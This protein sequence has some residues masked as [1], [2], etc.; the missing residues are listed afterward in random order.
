MHIKI[1]PYQMQCF[2]YHDLVLWVT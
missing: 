2:Y 1:L